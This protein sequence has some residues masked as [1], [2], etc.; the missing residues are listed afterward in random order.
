MVSYPLRDVLFLKMPKLLRLY[1][2]VDGKNMTQGYLAELFIEDKRPLRRS[3]DGLK[4]LAEKL[5]AS[6]C[7]FTVGRSTTRGEA[8]KYGRRGEYR[9]VL[10][11]DRQVSNFLRCYEAEES[12]LWNGG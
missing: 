5:V 10:L 1:R 2:V 6:G 8:S 12:K 9:K 7:S 4:K 11:G 3:S